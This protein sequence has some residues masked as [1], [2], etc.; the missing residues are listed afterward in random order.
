MNLKSTTELINKGVSFEEIVVPGGVHTVEDVERAC[1]CFKAEVIKTLLFVGQ[2]PVL[3]IM[4]GNKKVDMEKLKR[5]CGD[6]S[7]RMANKG[8]VSNLTGY[9]VGTVSP[10]G[11]R[12]NLEVIADQEV[13]SLVSLIMGSGKDDTLLKMSQANFTNAFSGTFAPLAL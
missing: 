10:F 12:G 2:K 1:Q 11:I 4:T 8:E 13:R 9:A 6:N 3:V 7:L 5:V